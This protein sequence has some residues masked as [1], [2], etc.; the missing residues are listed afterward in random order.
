MGLCRAA[1]AQEELIREYER[2][3]QQQT[4]E[5]D[6]YV[7]R[8]NREFADFLKQEWKLFQSMQA[9]ER[10]D[11]PKPDRAPVAP[12]REIPKVPGPKVEP[13][14]V[15]LPDLTPKPIPDLKP[16]VPDV[17]PDVPDVK[18]DAPRR[19]PQTLEFQFLRQSGEPPLFR[20]FE[21]GAGRHCGGTGG[22][23]VGA[24]E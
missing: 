8:R 14:P 3:R 18:P 12:D 22:G 2:F 13:L 1:T 17:K 16:D 6:D 9:V 20:P 7:S 4:R 11:E 23:L 5:F 21:S 15:P 24:D 19:L 10:P